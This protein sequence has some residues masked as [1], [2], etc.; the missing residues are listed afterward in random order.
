M[1]ERKLTIAALAA[2]GLVA[3]GAGL[4]AQQNGSQ[5]V[6]RP[7]QSEPKKAAASDRGL[8]LLTEAR[9]ATA[10][11]ILALDLGA[12]STWAGERVISWPRYPSGPIG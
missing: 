3:L 7:G 8:K 10:R 1:T 4:L 6:G 2:V 12:S 11:E 9:I 5:R